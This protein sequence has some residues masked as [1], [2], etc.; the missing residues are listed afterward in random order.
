M[1]LI[2]VVMSSYNYGN[3]I[4]EAIDSVLAQTFSDLEL[5]IV[6]DASEDNSK[7]IIRD[8]MNKYARIKAIFHEE[9]LGISRTVNDGWNA[10][11]GKFIASISADDIWA[12]DKLEKQFEVL[13]KDE[14]LVVW[15]EGEI[16]DRHGMATGELFSTVFG[17]DGRRKNGDIFEELLRG[18]FILASSRIFKK[19]CLK[20]RKYSENLKYLSD[21]RFAVDMANEFEYY[22]IEEPLTKYRM[23]GN[24]TANRD[25]EGYQ[26]DTVKLAEYFLSTYGDEIPNDIRVHLHLSSTNTLRYQLIQ[27]NSQ[28]IKANSRLSQAEKEIEEMKRSVIWRALMAYQ[29]KVVEKGLPRNTGRRRAYDSFIEGCRRL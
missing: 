8:Y 11:S 7:D 14:D 1:P 5:I 19:D 17:A 16:I 29:D 4:F 13:Q 22:F 20:G 21:Y 27:T 28:L 6:D 26:D 2:S 24:N 18:N 12:R 9:N 25:I 10:A 15:T 23:H 3:Y